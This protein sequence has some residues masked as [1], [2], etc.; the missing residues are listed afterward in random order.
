MR[1][2]LAGIMLN[3]NKIFAGSR[4]FFKYE[5]KKALSFIN[6]VHLKSDMEETF[7]VFLTLSFPD[8]HE[9][10]LHRLLPNSNTYLGK[11]VVNNLSEIPVG[12]DPADYIEAATDNRLR[13]EAVANNGDICSAYLNKKFWLF[14]ANVLQP[15]GVIDYIIRVE[16]QYR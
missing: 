5:G 1:F 2:I 3:Y 16:L 15:M 9:D 10:A 13:S 12:A 14:F 11:I 7:N 4:Q 6:F 8:L